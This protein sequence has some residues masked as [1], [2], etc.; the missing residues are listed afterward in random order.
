M[1]KL[2]IATPGSALVEAYL[3]EIAKAYAIDWSPPGAVV[4]PDDSDDDGGG[5]KVRSG[6]SESLNYVLMIV[7]CRSYNHPGSS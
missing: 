3:S 5:L 7:L 1:N 2:A 4:A 6:V